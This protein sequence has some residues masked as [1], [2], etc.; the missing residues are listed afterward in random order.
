MLGMN[1]QAGVKSKN[2]EQQHAWLKAFRNFLEPPIIPGS[3]PCRFLLL[4]WHRG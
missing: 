3:G 2:V 4:P 1:L